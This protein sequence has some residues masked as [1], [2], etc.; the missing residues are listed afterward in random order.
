M[1]SILWCSAGIDVLECERGNSVDV[2]YRLVTAKKTHCRS[3]EQ[4]VTQR[5]HMCLCNRS[6]RRCR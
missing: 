1:R 4:S 2:V 3:L 6:K 5:K